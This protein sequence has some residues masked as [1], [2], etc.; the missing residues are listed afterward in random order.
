MKKT[1]AGLLVASFVVATIAPAHAA[2]AK[3]GGVE[4]FLSGC[5][6]GAR[7]A[8]DYNTEGTGER[9]FVPWLLVGCC[10]GGRTQIDYAQGKDIHWRDWGRLI[11]YA[12]VVFA[13]WDGLD[14]ANG[15]T[16]PG[17][18]ETYGSTYY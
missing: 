1:V 12:G 9:E 15:V 5:C 13:V 8:A 6:L 11:P 17:I 18:A 10:L 3:K 2:E 14:G 4:G 16:R 7:T